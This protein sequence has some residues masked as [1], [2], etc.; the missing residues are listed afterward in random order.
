MTTAK[1]T[2]TKQQRDLLEERYDLR[3]DTV[4]GV[5]MTKGQ[6][7][8]GD[9]AILR[10]LRGRNAGLGAHFRALRSVPPTFSNPRCQERNA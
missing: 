4:A 3:D 5:T 10:L 1:A 2:I 9:E 6:K 7:K 8:I